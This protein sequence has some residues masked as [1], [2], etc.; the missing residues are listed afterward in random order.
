MLRCFASCLVVCLFVAPALADQPKFRLLFD[1]NDPAK[2][3]RPF[4][5]SGDGKVVVGRSFRSP[6]GFDGAFRWT[7]DTGTV[8]LP[9]PATGEVL[10]EALDVSFDGSVIVG[11]TDTEFFSQQQPFRWTADGGSEILPLLQGNYA[12]AVS[13]DGAT[14]VDGGHLTTGN[15]FR[16]TESGGTDLL[17]NLCAGY[18]SQWAFDVSADGTLIL[19]GDRYLGVPT[20]CDPFDP[21][22]LLGVGRL[23]SD[24]GQVI[25]GTVQI[26]RAGAPFRWSEAD[27]YQRLFADPLQT[28]SVEGITADGSMIVGQE[29]PTGSI[30]SRAYYWDVEHGK[31]SLADVLSDDFGFGDKLA[32]WTFEEATGISADGRTIIGTAFA[33]NR[34][35][36]GFVVTVPEPSGVVL[37][38][39]GN[40][41]A[42]VTMRRKRHH[43]VRLGSQGQ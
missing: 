29:G 28:G 24:D 42:A 33:P 16:W 34:G 20:N 23:L 40:A 18:D 25:A 1:P 26:S 17:G 38:L 43:Q 41:I 15:A 11:G 3:N 22:D 19:G 8:R 2:S 32:E 10:L 14:V 36:F 4:A 37:M 31:R 7:L 9:D 27:G 39:I 13:A 12:I 21:L 35:R 5:V 6:N 30:F